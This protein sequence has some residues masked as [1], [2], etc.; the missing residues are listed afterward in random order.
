MNI[1]QVTTIFGVGA[2]LA[3]ATSVITG[4]AI[5]NV[6]AAKRQRRLLKHPFARR[7][8]RRPLISVV[9]VDAEC[10]ANSLKQCLLS[11]AKN[12][13]PKHEILLTGRT[14]NTSI[15]RTAKQA[16]GELIVVLYGPAELA[17]GVLKNVVW[18]FATDTKLRTLTLKQQSFS[19]A[20]LPGLVQRFGEL[21]DGQLKKLL[22][23]AGS[24][25]RRYASDIVIYGRNRGASAVIFRA[26]AAKAVAPAVQKATGA[27]TAGLQRLWL[28][29]GLLLGSYGVYLALTRSTAYLLA[30][31][32]LGLSVF[33]WLAVWDDEHLKL[34]QKSKLSL[35]VPVMLGPLYL[36]ALL[37]LV[38]IPR[39]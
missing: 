25:R 1:V 34:W 30:I 36:A 38:T 24:R 2:L 8:R 14:K 13:Y 6:L 7:L 29:I 33:L 4:A 3:G 20:S 18:R 39:K 26:G 31:I 16:R 35:L 19:N 27:I 32:W 21:A 17:P 5:Y 9:V 23:V 37:R 28:A 15:I 22:D 10:D 11:I 12:G